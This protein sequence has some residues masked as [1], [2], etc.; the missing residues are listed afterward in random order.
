M[1]WL[2]YI[3]RCAEGVV[4]KRILR[5][6]QPRFFSLSSAL[7]SHT[8]RARGLLLER[9]MDGLTIFVKNV[10]ECLTMRSRMSPCKLQ[11][12]LPL[13]QI[14]T[15][16]NC[17]CHGKKTKPRCCNLKWLKK[18][19]RSCNLKFLGKKIIL[20]FRRNPLLICYWLLAYFDALFS[21]WWR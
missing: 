10:L 19:L 17:T 20:I 2:L 7:L 8:D 1:Q 13:R 12:Q 15:S 16:R 3:T 18:K 14:L 9:W 4:P 5:I 6:V 11:Q 21:F